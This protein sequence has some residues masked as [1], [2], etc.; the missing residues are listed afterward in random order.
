MKCAY[1]IMNLNLL[2]LPICVIASQLTKTS[3]YADKTEKE[4]F[5]IVI[6]K[7]IQMGSVAKGF[8][9]YEEMRKYLIIYEK[10]DPFRIFFFI[11][12][13]TL[14]CGM[15][16]VVYVRV[17]IIKTDLKIYADWNFFDPVEYRHKA[18]LQMSYGPNPPGR[19]YNWSK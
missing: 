19:I 1:S 14:P 6:Y 15:V 4:I 11:T 3:P 18:P 16:Y 2:C 9:I 8:L 7:E 12:Q 5:L 17:A 10:A 13:C